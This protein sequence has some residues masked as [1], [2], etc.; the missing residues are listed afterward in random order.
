M[1]KDILRKSLSLS[2]AAVFALTTALQ[3]APVKTDTLRPAALK[4]SPS[5]QARADLEVLIEDPTYFLDRSVQVAKEAL[6]YRSNEWPYDIEIISNTSDDER[7]LREEEMR[8]Y[9]RGKVGPSGKPVVVLSVIEEW[10]K[11]GA[12]NLLGTPFALMTATRAARED[13]DVSGILR[14]SYGSNDLQ[15]LYEAGRIKIRHILNGGRAKRCNGLNQAEHSS[16]GS[17]K[18]FG[19]VKTYTEDGKLQDRPI[20]LFALVAATH[21]SLAASNDGTYIDVIYAGQSALPSKDVW[22]AK[23]PAAMITKFAQQL[24]GDKAVTSRNLRDLGVYEADDDLMIKESRPKGS[25]IDQAGS[26]SVGVARDWLKDHTGYYS[27]GSHRLHRKFVVALMEF[28]KQALE[29][30]HNINRE[31]PDFIKPMVEL[32]N[33]VEHLGR[34]I[35]SVEDALENIPILAGE[36]DAGKAFMVGLNKDQE[37]KV[38]EVIE[39]YLQYRDSLLGEDEQ[40]LGIFDMGADVYWDRYRRPLEYA[41]ANLLLLSIFGKNKLELQSDG[42]CKVTRP[43]RRDM[44]QA[45][46]YAEIR[47]I[48]H[49]IASCRLGDVRIGKRGRLLDDYVKDGE[50][51]LPKGAE[52]T[53]EMVG[54]GIEIGGVRIR[55]AL[56][57]NS[58]LLP[59]SSV[60][61]SLVENTRM[62]R[63]RLRAKNA[64]VE[65]STGPEFRVRD[66]LLYNVLTDKPRDVRGE[67]L[68]G[69]QREQLPGGQILLILPFDFDGQENHATPLGDI[70]SIAASDI[71]TAPLEA[72]TFEGLN[73]MNAVRRNNATRAGIE[74]RLL[75]H[76]GVS[77]ASAA[78]RELKGVVFDLDGV[79]TSTADI[80]YEEWRKLFEG[81]FLKP[82]DGSSPYDY[83]LRTLQYRDRKEEES[84][85]AFGD[86]TKHTPEYDCIAEFDHHISPDSP[87]YAGL[88]IEQREIMD[89]IKRIVDEEIR[90]QGAFHHDQHYIPYVD[91]RARYDGCLGMYLTANVAAF[92]CLKPLYEGKTPSYID[93]KLQPDKYAELTPQQKKAMDLVKILGDYKDAGVK[94]HLQERPEDVQVLPGGIEILLELRAEGI[95][96][97]IAS[98]SKNTP[99]VLQIVFEREAERLGTSDYTAFFNTVVS[100]YDIKTHSEKLGRR[101]AGKPEPDIFLEAA[102]RMGVEA[103]NCIGFEDAV[104]GVEAIAKAG[105]ICIGL[106]PDDRGELGKHADVVI[107]FL[108][109]IDINKMLD[110][111]IAEGRSSSAGELK[112]IVF[113]LDG[114][115]TSTRDMH[116]AEWTKMFNTAFKEFGLGRTFTEDDYDN[117][118]DG[119]PGPSG[120]LRMFIAAGVPQAECLGNMIHFID[121]NQPD[122][123][124]KWDALTGEQ[125]EAMDLVSHWS[126]VKNASYKAFIKAHPGAISI[127][128]GAIE[129]I[130][131]LREAGIPMNVASSSRSTVD[132]LRYTGLDRYFDPEKVA[133]GNDMRKY[134]PELGKQVEGKPAGDIFVLA[135]KRMGLEPEECIGFED[136]KDG[137]RA[138]KAAGMVCVAV[139]AKSKGNLDEHL[140]EN[141]MKTT[142]LEELSAQSLRDL[143]AAKASAAGGLKAALFDL[144]GVVTSTKEVHFEAWQQVLSGEFNIEITLDDYRRYLD[145]KT[146]Y[147]GCLDIVRAKSIDGF[148]SLARFVHFI[149]R[150]KQARAYDKLTRVQRAA[151][152][153]IGELADKKNAIYIQEIENHPERIEILPG[154]EELLKALKQA[155]IGTALVSSSKT[156]Q[157]I[158]ELAGL[159]DNFDVIISGHDVGIFNDLLDK[160]IQGK[161]EPD[162]FLLAAKRLK[163]EPAD[164]VAFEDS[165]SGIDAI[166]RAGMKAVGVDARNDGSLNDGSDKVITD[167]SVIDIEQMQTLVAG[168][169]SSAGLIKGV[170]FDSDGVISSTETLHFE[171]WKRMFEEEFARHSGEATVAEFTYELH[172][173]HVLGR[174][175]Y[176]GA[177]LM[178]ANSGIRE[179]GC[180]KGIKHHVD[181]MKN[182]VEYRALTSDQQTA[183][184][185]IKA[186][187]NTKNGYYMGLVESRPE[188]IV[189]LPGV[190]NLLKALK[191][192]GIKIALISSS[193]N[194]PMVIDILFRKRAE[195]LGT[196]DPSEIF[197]VVIAGNALGQHSI[198]ISRTVQ[199]KP[200]PDIFLEAA[201]RL[202]LNP[203]NCIGVEDAEAG[204][205]AIKAAGMFAVG[206]NFGE[207]K[208]DQGLADKTYDSLVEMDVDNLEKE[209]EARLS[210]ASSAGEFKE[211]IRAAQEI[212]LGVL[213]GQLNQSH[214]EQA[215]AA[216]RAIREELGRTS[217]EDLSRDERNHLEARIGANELILE[218]AE[219]QAAAARTFSDGQVIYD[220]RIIPNEQQRDAVIRE[221]K[222][223]QE[224][225]EDA[226]ALRT[227]D[228]Q[229]LASTQVVLLEDIISGKVTLAKNAVIISNDTEVLPQLN[230]RIMPAGI[231]EENGLFVTQYL[232]A[233]ARGCLSI[234]EHN[235]NQ[236]IRNLERLWARVTGE[237]IPD[238]LRRNLQNGTWDVVYLIIT[239]IPDLEALGQDEVERRHRMSWA[240]LIA[241]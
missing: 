121:K 64:F 83:Y 78:G 66:G 50:V 70:Q 177:M 213:L 85:R 29:K 24:K 16:R 167:L 126:E 20:T 170:I 203:E 183:M 191:E 206:V 65:N 76:F 237:L 155:G 194:T 175:R 228:D 205:A 210:R 133:Y 8:A 181:D 35:T 201:A 119:V 137:V 127:L 75:K 51:V 197:D 134:S 136:A 42:T 89:N 81:T 236:L 231:T 111:M 230:R 169:A 84:I 93:K 187:A 90:V 106:D 148:R 202:R 46:H 100:G 11:G 212:L 188:E 160:V 225:L 26:V 17:L 141:D 171:A 216:F 132:I 49:P 102:A 157:Y 196:S 33:G 23:T 97:A 227:V 58:Q 168:K 199:G 18:V 27:Y 30:D 19:E 41:N 129:L 55:G 185:R 12:G 204:I 40:W 152:D 200:E 241:A 179:F 163:A 31:P 143:F 238:D 34:D 6:D 223:V 195:E 147:D 107:E 63:K 224:D 117:H 3:A 222:A 176:D 104:A 239:L 101:I 128:P 165:T 36:G 110:W 14:E 209:M 193:R 57:R 184:D 164:C 38:R 28:Y 114:V 88:T 21:A 80:H 37:N 45:K 112:G 186:L 67:S 146:R 118:V 72:L 2:L 221:F 182:P 5:G 214:I 73:D 159:L 229:V 54:E 79:I 91:G 154:V 9:T 92:E 156:S 15:E 86:I 218:H 1:F 142:T 59:G 149:D 44:Q 235:Y 162:T 144:D 150:E 98:S 74:D 207:Y 48:T 56:L 32:L 122:D 139:D 172:R 124:E 77:K 108:S 10:G 87:E 13:G 68:L 219:L 198:L 120:C 161:P 135:A 99:K 138:I 125:Q 25:F 173:K 211:K 153:R 61:N 192:R 215:K 39:F 96:I 116:V 62:L 43:S 71:L 151:M 131:D 145:G 190:A 115:L 4:S 226:M 220:P 178:L 82:E 60:I 94:L 180:L 109:E 47:H 140:G 103:L 166:K 158:L 130:E 105:M 53:F 52:I 208:L 95:N 217:T 123:Q 234:N 233:F 174:P 189:L 22:T 7:E 232:I 240:A 113:D 69:I